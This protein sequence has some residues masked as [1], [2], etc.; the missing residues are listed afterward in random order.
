VPLF[1]FTD[2][3]AP[4]AA[5]G[6]AIGRIGCFLSGCCYG[7][8]STFPWAVAYPATHETHGLPVH[9]APLYETTLMLV[10][11]GLLLRLDQKKRFEGFT[12]GSFFVFA[13]LVRFILEYIPR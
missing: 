8:A 10:V 7:S 5:L 3:V 4:S 13:G 12:T 11:M 1:H 2:I 9:P 6:L